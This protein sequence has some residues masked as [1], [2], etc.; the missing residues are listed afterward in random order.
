MNVSIVRG[1]PVAAVLALAACGS[2]GSSGSSSNPT[3]PSGVTSNVAT[4]NILGDKGSQSFFPNPIGAVSA[5]DGAP[6]P[7]RGAYC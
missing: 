2:S 7:R 4:I 1:A 6:P 5:N 3:A